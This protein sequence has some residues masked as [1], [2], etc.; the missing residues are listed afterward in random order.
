[1][2][3]CPFCKGAVSKELL[4]QGGTCP[5][6]L[7]EIPGEEAPTDPGAQALAR[8]QEEAAAATGGKG[9]LIGAAIAVV[10]LVGAGGGWY[11][12][13]SVQQAKVQ[14]AA[15]EWS[16]LSLDVHQNQYVEETDEAKARGSV[17]GGGGGGGA[18][19]SVA[20]STGGQLAS[21]GSSS[22]SRSGINPSASYSEQVA[23]ADPTAAVQVP[24]SGVSSSGLGSPGG[25]SGPGITIGAKGAQEVLSDPAEIEAMVKRVVT[26]NGKQ[27]EDCYNDRL[28]SDETLQGRWNVTFTISTKGKTQSIGVSGLNVA[29]PELEGCMQKRITAWQFSPISEDIAM[30]RTYTFRP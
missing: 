11:A 4:L 5:H 29:D 3:H 23:L 21:T 25:I 26:R 15:D 24:V 13:S 2:G 16:V 1:M 10:L 6:C 18:T 12:W 19:A 17:R 7:I 14:A 9:P 22:P 8:Q 30:Q 20:P 27:L 28:K